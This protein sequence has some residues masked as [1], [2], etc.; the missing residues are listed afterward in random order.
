MKKFIFVTGVMKGTY[1]GY[2]CDQEHDY[3]GISLYLGVSQG[4]TKEAAWI[5]LYEKHSLDRYLTDLTKVVGFEVVGDG[6]DMVLDQA[7]IS[8]KSEQ[9]PVIK[10]GN[11]EEKQCKFCK[12]KVPSN[13]AA[14]FSHLKKHI[15]ELLSKNLLTKEQAAGIRS[16][17][18][19][20]AIEKIFI[21]KFGVH[22]EVKA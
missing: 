21:E 16:L 19:E 14:Q 9:T 3:T 12:A 15:N 4:E 20:P 18:L 8:A 13:G 1:Q 10:V 5:T 7:K 17:K 11:Y 6:H 2:N 22:E